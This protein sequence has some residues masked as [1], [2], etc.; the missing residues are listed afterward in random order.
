MAAAVANPSYAFTFEH[1]VGRT[2]GNS[3]A[4]TDCVTDAG[5]FAAI[6]RDAGRAADDSTRA[7]FGAFV[8][9]AD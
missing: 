8:A 6:N 9:M 7:M 3:G 1:D 5:H 4:A 2:A